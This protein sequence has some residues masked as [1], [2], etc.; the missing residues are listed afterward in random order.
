MEAAMIERLRTGAARVGV[1][2]DG[3][4]L[5][6]LERFFSFLIIWNARINLTAVREEGAIVER[7]FVDSLAV[8]PV[9]AHAPGAS[10]LV[11]VGSGGGFPGA[12][13]AVARPDL[14]VSLIEST[15]KKVAFLQTLKREVAPNLEPI[16]ARVEDVRASGRKFDIAVSRA[17]FAPAEWLD[18]GS[19][20]VA[21]GGLL[22]AMLG[23]ERPLLHP[24][25]GFTTLPFVDYTIEDAQRR[26]VVCQR[27]G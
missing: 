6:R 15:H 9:L 2:L 26:L 7:H 8:A 14:A 16:A 22:V 17:T 27:Q 3:D 24:P 11:D 21:P 12:V 4:Q 5:A 20:L 1:T 19:P 25:E 18:E 13:L 23:A 10:T